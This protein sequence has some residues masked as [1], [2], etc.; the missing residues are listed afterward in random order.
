MFLATGNGELLLWSSILAQTHWNSA[1]RD[2]K[3]LS[4]LQRRPELQV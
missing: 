1:F 3:G 2:A 4:G